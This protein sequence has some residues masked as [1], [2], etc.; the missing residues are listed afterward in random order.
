MHCKKIWLHCKLCTGTIFASD[1]H[2]PWPPHRNNQSLVAAKF[3]AQLWRSSLIAHSTCE[4]K[5]GLG[6]RA[7][8]IIFFI[9]TGTN[10]KEGGLLSGHILP[11]TLLRASHIGKWTRTPYSTGCPLTKK[12]NCP[13]T[14]LV[15]VSLHRSIKSIRKKRRNY[16][17][18][19]WR[20][21]SNTAQSVR[22]SHGH[23]RSFNFCKGSVRTWSKTT[24]W[25]GAITS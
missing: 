3:W 11:H 25:C 24:K 18:R 21:R 7:Y 12:I 20:T 14:T 6:E 1:L 17:K 9:H 4:D 8:S 10:A 2:K 15:S 19:T 16:K 13:F 23:V 22:V 5:A